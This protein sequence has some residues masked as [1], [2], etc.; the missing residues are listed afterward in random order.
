MLTRADITARLTGDRGQPLVPL[1]WWPQVDAA[2]DDP[3]V[4]VVVLWMARQGGKTQKLMVSAIEDLLTKADS[5]TVFV[6]AGTEQAES[7][8]KRK[9]RLPLVRLLRSAG[10]SASTMR[11]TKRSIENTALNSQI[12]VVA[13]SEVTS[14]GRSVSRLI[15]DEARFI[16]D[17]VFAALAPSV[18]AA[19]GKILVA[20]TAGPPKGF[21]HALCTTDD[22]EVRV[23]RVDTNANPHADQGIIGFLGR[24][25]RKILPVAAARDL[26]NQFV[27][28]GTEFLPGPL[29]DAAVDPHLGEVKSSPRPTY[30]FLDLSRKRDITSLVLVL[31][32]LPRRPEAGDHLQAAA[33]TTWDPKE[34]PTGEVDFREVRAVLADLPRRFPGLTKILVDEGAEAGSVLP[35]ARSHPALSLVV[36]GFN[37][38][39]ENNMKLWSALAA[40]LHAGTLTIPA[41]TRLVAELRSLRQEAVALGAKW[42]VIDQSKRLH[43]DVSVALAGA[44]LAAGERRRC[45]HCDDVA[46]NGFHI[47]GGG[48]MP[49]PRGKFA[50]IRSKP[51]EDEIRTA[52]AKDAEDQKA[53]EREQQEEA[54]RVVR[55]AISQRGCYWPGGR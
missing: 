1:A 28:D 24:L 35:F 46:C 54:A 18:I 45:E 17:D 27:G 11:V 36:E 50:G 53:I 31:R 6:S 16:P 55:D 29:I 12:D 39:V 43:R 38:T 13:A 42:R 32:D 49:L 5:Y 14:P 41:H 44:C 9:L 19:N 33:I 26:D 40:R 48:P 21:F 25:L 30:G 37:P 7:N 4:R 3:A 52:H 22:P 34:S 8:F 15:I 51:T 10:L 47:L 2:L 20:S 23:I